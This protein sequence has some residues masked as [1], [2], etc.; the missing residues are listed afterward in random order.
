MTIPSPLNQLPRISIVTPS[1]NYGEFIEQTILS[2]ISQGYPNLEYIIIDGGSTDNSVEIIK[3][4]QNYLAY[5]ESVPDRGQAHAI[6]KGLQRA[7]GDIFNWI[8][9]DDILAEG[10]LLNIAANWIPGH[11]LATSVVNFASIDDIHTHTIITNKNLL[12]MGLATR[13]ESATFH[14]PGL[15]ADCHLAKRFQFDESLSYAFDMT[16]YINYFS[17]NP[18]IIY[19]SD[20]T[21]YF[22]LHKDSKSVRDRQYFY[23]EKTKAL[24][25]LLS[26]SNL[27]RHKRLLLV[28][29]CMQRLVIKQSEFA[30]DLSLPKRLLLRAINSVYFRLLTFISCLPANSINK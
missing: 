16:Y 2:I 3:K 12:M 29:A 21:V 28:F 15:W 8:N 10:A 25:G 14:Q 23:D 22:R 20:V 19:K 9:A 1:Y 24:V 27:P 11:L 26:A 30:S 7:S 13:Y 5:W 6:N 17:D 4:Y 18:L